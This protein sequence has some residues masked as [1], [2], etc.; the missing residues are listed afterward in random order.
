VGRFYWSECNQDRRN[1][2]LD[3]SGF[4]SC[5]SYFQFLTFS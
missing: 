4:F 2:S 1:W 5:K 3:S